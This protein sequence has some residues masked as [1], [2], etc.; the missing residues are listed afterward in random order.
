MR[1]ITGGT[2][3]RRDHQIQPRSTMLRDGVHTSPKKRTTPNPKSNTNKK[4]YS[5]LECLKVK[6][7]RSGNLEYG[8]SWQFT[9][10]Q[11][12]ISF[13]FWVNCNELTQQETTRRRSPRNSKPSEHVVNKRQTQSKGINGQADGVS[14]RPLVGK[15]LTLLDLYEEIVTKHTGKPKKV[16]NHS[17]KISKGYQM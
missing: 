3:E 17:T 13:N 6:C 12:Q 15:R 8:R 4:R 5:N 10:F 11:F 2:A 14:T 7:K 9:I 1:R 16:E